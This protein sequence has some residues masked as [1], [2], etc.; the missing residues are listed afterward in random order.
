MFLLRLFCDTQE[1]HKVLI[2]ES[3]DDYKSEIIKFK[4]IYPTLMGVVNI[5]DYYKMDQQTK[6]EWQ[7]HHVKLDKLKKI[8]INNL[9]NYCENYPNEKI[10]KNR[11]INEYDEYPYRLEL[12]ISEVLLD[13]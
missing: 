5:D 10:T 7:E 8:V 9:I 3:F 6:N 11:V 4:K 2:R 1:M 13:L 12:N